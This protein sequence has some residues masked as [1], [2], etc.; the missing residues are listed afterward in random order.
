M[1]HLM[2]A[3][4]LRRLSA[5]VVVTVIAALCGPSAQADPQPVP[6]NY[7]KEDQLWVNKPAKVKVTVPKDTSIHLLVRDID[8]RTNPM[9]PAFDFKVYRADV[10]RAEWHRAPAALHCEVTVVPNFKQP[11]E[12]EFETNCINRMGMFS[13]ESIKLWDNPEVTTKG[14][15]KEDLDKDRGLHYWEFKD[16]KWFKTKP[17]LYY[18]C[19]GIEAR[20]KL[21][22]RTQSIAFMHKGTYVFMFIV[23]LPDVEEPAKVEKGQPETPDPYKKAREAFYGKVLD[24][25]YFELTK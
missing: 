2:C 5:A 9:M 3:T 20:A 18:S 6:E 13:P 14:G 11:M 25:K 19:S 17:V 23:S 12:K 4:N 16:Q 22:L 10:P 8:E 24:S 15:K 7:D 1:S 21:I